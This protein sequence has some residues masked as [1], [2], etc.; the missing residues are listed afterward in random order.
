MGACRESEDGLNWLMDVCVRMRETSKKKKMEV[1]GSSSR[2][3]ILTPYEAPMHFWIEKKK[4]FKRDKIP[5][6]I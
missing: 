3:K 4:L 2:E 1:W 6:E 5:L